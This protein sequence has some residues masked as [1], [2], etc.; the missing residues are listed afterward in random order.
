MSLALLL[1]TLC[2]AMAASIL[3]QTGVKEVTHDTVPSVTCFTHTLTLSRSPVVTVG[4][5][6]AASSTLQ[7]T[8]IDLH[9]HPAVTCPTLRTHTRRVTW[10]CI[11]TLRVGVAASSVALQAE[12]DGGT[13]VTVTIISIPTHT[14]SIQ[15]CVCT[16]CVDVTVFL[17][18][19]RVARRG[20]PVTVFSGVSVHTG[21]SPTY[22]TAAWTV[23]TL[24]VETAAL[25]VALVS[26]LGWI[27]ADVAGDTPEA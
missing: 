11:H 7:L 1:L 18:S 22:A 24:T 21:T 4:V 23:I 10:T 25:F 6:A 27:R 2:Q 12:V 26:V 20:R 14:F 16:V 15:S 8:V 13:G 19:V 17:Q 9:T 3:E 5:G